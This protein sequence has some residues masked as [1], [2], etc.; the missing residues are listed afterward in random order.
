MG[1]IGLDRA[2]FQKYCLNF[3]LQIH[4]VLNCSTKKK[5]NC[6]KEWEKELSIDAS[7]ANRKCYTITILI[8]Q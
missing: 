5:K 7:G 3:D 8:A 4:K 2:S 1:R 6:R